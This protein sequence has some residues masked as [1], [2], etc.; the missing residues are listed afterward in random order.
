MKHS[1][2]YLN[3]V[4]ETLPKFD[5]GAKTQSLVKLYYIKLTNHT[6]H[7]T[8]VAKCHNLHAVTLFT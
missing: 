3:L 4:M 1:K 6:L 7:V 8:R 2:Q 5:L